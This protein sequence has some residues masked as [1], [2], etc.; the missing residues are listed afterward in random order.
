MNILSEHNKPIDSSF[1]YYLDRTKPFFK[2]VS[3][4]LANYI[5]CKT[6]QKMDLDGH[7]YDTLMLR[8]IFSEDELNHLC[9]MYINYVRDKEPEKYNNFYKQNNTYN[10]EEIIQSLSTSLKEKTG[11]YFSLLYAFCEHQLEE[12]Y[13]YFN[14]IEEIIKTDYMK[15]FLDTFHFGDEI[16]TLFVLSLFSYESTWPINS[17][18]SP[19][20]VAGI[21][22]KFH[23]DS[24]I[25]TNDIKNMN[26]KLKKLGIYKADFK[27][28]D[29]L[30]SI[31]T[32]DTDSLT[33]K[34]VYFDKNQDAF[35]FEA[36]SKQNEENLFVVNK[37][38]NVCRIND[39]GCYVKTTNAPEFRIK[40]FL[41]YNCHKNGY[42][43]F[44]IVAND[45]KIS[46]NNFIFYLIAISSQL[47]NQFVALYLGKD[48]LSKVFSDEDYKP[49]INIFA[50]ENDTQCDKNLIDYSVL[51]NI[52]IPVFLYNSNE[53]G[54]QFEFFENSLKITF[55]WNFEL[56]SQNDYENQLSKY[57]HKRNVSRMIIDDTV[58]E[59][60]EN[61]LSPEKW[62]EILQLLSAPACS[63]SSEEVKKIINSNYESQKEKNIRKK[64]HYS[65][66]AL[67]TSEPVQEIVQAIKNADNFQHH[68]Y[69]SESG[70][71]ILNY[72]PSGTGK[73]AYVEY[74]AKELDKPLEIV[75]ASDILGSY[76]GETEKN[77]KKTFK[78]AAK[79]KAILL[80]DEADSFIHSRG[81]TVNRHNDSKVNEFLVQMERY[82]GILFCNTN[83]PDTLDS[84]TDRRFHMKIEFEPLDENGIALLCQSYFEKYQFSKEQIKNIYNSGD[85]TPGDFGALFG[86]LR[87]TSADNLCAEYISNELI[88]M[89]KGKKRSWENKQQIGF[90]N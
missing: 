14:P 45:E 61:Q 35:S 83:L 32:D 53:Y 62:P 48:I 79:K 3:V 6:I 26:Q 60:Y 19:E 46:I 55:N 76:V 16:S 9:S 51:Q 36:I 80:I 56:P 28:N 73:T 12:K 86:R 81:D 18:F 52:Q 78:K 89:V 57:L 13:T 49:Q 43:L 8:G 33:I 85:V 50:S 70:I 39:N 42:R 66:E 30:Y 84:A 74:V 65:L 68:E 77:I 47:K 2:F 27:I 40:N 25:T 69:D 23:P 4:Q 88:K 10:F 90:G 24:I 38:L 75:R 29:F 15:N 5:Y 44:E 82:P 67:R 37:I 72:G 34:N 87:F 21:I 7:E 11:I 22:N 64:S 20:Y 31:L 63:F 58:K 17:T 54:N 71:R 1:Y 41:S 59:C